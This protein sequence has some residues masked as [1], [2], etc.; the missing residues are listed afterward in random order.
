MP[1]PPFLFPLFDQGQMNKDGLEQC[2]LG[3]AG[4]GLGGGDEGVG[5]AGMT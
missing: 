3:R 5:W 4:A 2:E 1:L